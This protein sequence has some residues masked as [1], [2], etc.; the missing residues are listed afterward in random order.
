[1]RTATFYWARLEMAPDLTLLENFK[2]L[3]FTSKIEDQ[4]L[5]ITASILG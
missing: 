3:A 2:L 1:M 4:R 5:Y